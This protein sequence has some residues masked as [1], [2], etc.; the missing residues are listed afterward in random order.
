MKKN[1]TPEF[2]NAIAYLRLSRDDRDRDES[3]SIKNQRDLILDFVNRNPDIR[4]AG[5]LADDGATGANFER[6]AFK[7]MIRRIESGEITAV[8]VKDFSRLGRD[9]IGTG[10]YI[11]RYF[12][13]KNVRF[14]AV[15]EPFDSLRDDLNDS[16]NSLLVP[17]KNIVN[18]AMLEDIS[19]KTRSQLEI[20]RKRGEMLCNFA[21]YGYI[22]SE[23]RLIVDEY[24]ANI[25]RTIFDRKIMGHSEQ[26]IADELNAAGIAS[27]A[28]YKK[29]MGSRY[30]TPFGAGEKPR[31]S[32]NAV[33][34]ILANRVYVGSLEQG[35]R[36][37][38]SY[39][40]RKYFYKPREAWIVRD[41]DH[42][43]IISE[44]DFELAR[45]LASK[46]TRLPSADGRLYLFSG[47]IVCG[48]CGQPMVVKTTTAKG[49]R[50][51]NYRC[52]THKR[53][54]ACKNN[55]VS[56][57]AVERFVLASVQRQIDALISAD[58]LVGALS[59]DAMRERKRAAVE[60]LIAKALRTVRDNNEY[61][62]KSYTA[63]VDGVISEAEYNMFRD[64]FRRQIADAES[65][66]EKLR[67]DIERLGDDTRTRA[68]ID[69]FKS[70]GDIG[71]LDRRTVVTLIESIV[72]NSSKDLVINFRFA[73]GLD[74]PEPERTVTPGG[75]KEQEAAI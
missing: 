43:A 6:K 49:K 39:R 4:V 68:I 72:A 14:V 73:S 60:S 42:E 41:G 27:P 3:D 10:K 37:K 51:I 5:I 24:A 40:V 74:A 8:L 46:D 64:N 67:G 56:G 17:F 52:A 50:Y 33:R 35:K 21:V 62:V 34:R 69:E 65:V 57:R 63:F 28:E 48:A 75:Q 53:N 15:T 12:A 32:G 1:E 36:T 44:L 13:S 16:A 58:A 31:W 19:N 30:A 20:K 55:N 11:Q 70:R 45:E 23:R 2:W 47:M 38:T 7:E 26:R 71:A 25:V 22:K 18:E 9:H 54:G 59:L 61:L 66:I 29:A